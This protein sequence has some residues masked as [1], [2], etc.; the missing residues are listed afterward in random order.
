[1][2]RWSRP[3]ARTTAEISRTC[4]RT[5]AVCNL[6]R[7]LLR[8]TRPRQTDCYA[9]TEHNA[10]W[11]VNDHDEPYTTPAGQPFSWQGRTRMVGGRTNVW[12]RQ[13]YRFSQQDLKG[14]SFDGAGADWPLL[15]D[16]APYY[17][18]VERYVGIS[19]QAEKRSG[20]AR[21]PVPAADADD[22]LGEAAG[23]RAKK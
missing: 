22:L 23:A 5:A 18:L 11:F 8:K 12:G 3:A 21:Q 16:L 14:R 4:G 2:W 19:G 6:S 15:N 13:S 10:D 17:D 7:E 9:C 20:A 1:M